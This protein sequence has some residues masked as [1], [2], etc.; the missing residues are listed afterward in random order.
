MV[1][2]IVTSTFTSVI[3][4][5][6]EVISTITEVYKSTVVDTTRQLRIIL[7]VGRDQ[8]VNLIQII[9]GRLLI[10]SRTYYSVPQLEFWWPLCGQA[11]FYH[12][13]LIEFI[14]KQPVIH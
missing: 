2:P 9:L 8:D 12:P 11:E 5:F 3:S 14:T 6:S 10:S 4:T 7:C 13:I 1:F